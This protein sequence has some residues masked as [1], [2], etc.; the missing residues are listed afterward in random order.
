V[1][2]SIKMRKDQKHELV[3]QSNGLLLAGRRVHCCAQLA[4]RA[5]QRRRQLGQT[6][7]ELGHD[8]SGTAHPARRD[9]YGHGT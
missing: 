6:E 7:A 2:A 1:L 5:A 8:S 4:V 9:T 3:G